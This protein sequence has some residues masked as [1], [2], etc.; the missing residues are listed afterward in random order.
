MKKKWAALCC[1][2][3]LTLGGCAQSARQPGITPAELDSEQRL[4]LNMAG[5]SDQLYK[6]SYTVPEGAGKLTFTMEYYRDGKRVEAPVAAPLSDELFSFEPKS[7]DCAAGSAGTIWLSVYPENNGH[8]GD[9]LGQSDFFNNAILSR[10]NIAVS[11]EKAAGQ[12]GFHTGCGFEE[13]VLQDGKAYEAMRYLAGSARPMALDEEILLCGFTLQEN[14]AG[15]GLPEELAAE[16]E[17]LQNAAYAY[18]LRAK[19]TA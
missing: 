14:M 2:L 12:F 9:N 16:P 6:W 8:Y 11:A 13:P 15:T 19:F 4:I 10:W 17:R 5:R 1:A 7:V 3:L 18:L